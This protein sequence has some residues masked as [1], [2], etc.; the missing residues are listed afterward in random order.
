MVTETPKKDVHGDEMY[1]KPLHVKTG[2]TEAALYLSSVGNVQAWSCPQR[3]SKQQ[4][5]GDRTDS[6]TAGADTGTIK[7][8]SQH[9]LDTVTMRLSSR[10]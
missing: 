8:H 4:M 6:Q 7:G 2:K 5:L 9:G 1:M 10:G 3:I